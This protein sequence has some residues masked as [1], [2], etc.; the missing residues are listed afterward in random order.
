MPDN[1]A[2]SVEKKATRELTSNRRHTDSGQVL[3]Q[4]PTVYAASVHRRSLPAAGRLPAGAVFPLARAPTQNR[5]APCRAPALPP[6]APIHWTPHANHRMVSSHHTVHTRPDWRVPLNG[7]TSFIGLC[8]RGLCGNRNSKT[9][10][11]MGS[12]GPSP[13]RKWLVHGLW[14]KGKAQSQ[15]VGGV[16]LHRGA[17]GSLGT[18]CHGKR[19]LLRPTGPNTTA[20]DTGHSDACPIPAR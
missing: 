14:A 1:W 5:A 11:D 17:A 8:E 19:Q 16:A 18:S 10:T 20:L 15:G 2:V 3:A 9:F 13:P 12:F 7:N 4:R 6:S